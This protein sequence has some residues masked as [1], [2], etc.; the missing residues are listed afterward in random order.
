MIIKLLKDNT[1]TATYE[2]GIK[3]NVNSGHSHKA[4]SPETKALAE[5]FVY[6]EGVESDDI[7]FNG[8]V[9]RSGQDVVTP[10]DGQPLDVRLATFC[11][12]VF[13]ENAKR[14]YILSLPTVDVVKTESVQNTVDVARMKLREI[15]I[16]G[17]M[18]PDPDG[19]MVPETA[20]A[21]F[22]VRDYD[23]VDGQAVQKIITMTENRVIIDQY[24]EADEAGNPIMIDVPVLDSEGQPE[25]F[26]MIQYQGSLYTFDQ[27]VAK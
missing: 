1:V 21:S 22:D 5:A 27:L 20:P 16:D 3:E 2:D 18:A 25:T 9:V 24:P 8:L 7:S 26:E 17:V 11:G 4:L 10:L 23:V 14:D 6:G 19:Q 12:I 13:G 15:E